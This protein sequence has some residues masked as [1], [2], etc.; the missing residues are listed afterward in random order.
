MG[1][2]GRGLGEGLGIAVG[3][4]AGVVVGVWVDAEVGTTLVNVGVSDE[5]GVCVHGSPVGPAVH[6][7][8][9]R[10]TSKQQPVRRFTFVRAIDAKH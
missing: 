4:G 8:R 7:H 1:S 6:A 9:A 10:A 5:T 3:D 2:A